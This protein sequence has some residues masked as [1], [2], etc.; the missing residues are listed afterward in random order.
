MFPDSFLP[1][2]AVT[3]GKG[4]GYARLVDSLLREKRGGEG[5]ASLQFS[6][7]QFTAVAIIYTILVQ[8]IIGECC[9][10]SI[11]VDSIKQVYYK[12]I[13]M[14]YTLVLH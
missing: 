12:N 2:V 5:G 14:P 1:R 11:K 4:S 10:T 13:K 8:K 3:V 6:I 9:M 7:Q